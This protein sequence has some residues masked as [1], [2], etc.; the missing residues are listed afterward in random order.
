MNV[1]EDNKEEMEEK[2]S[3]EEMEGENRE[4][5]PRQE[6]ASKE[7]SGEEPKAEE[8]PNEE[9]SGEEEAPVEEA[10]SDEGDGES[11]EEGAGM[12]GGEPKERGKKKMADL[13]KPVKAGD[14]IEVTIESVGAKGDGIAKKDGFV[15]FVPGV[16]KGDTVK[17]KIVE[18][19]TSFA[20]GEKV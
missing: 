18:L 10:A 9:E 8:A 6:E 12:E 4:E 2:E 11:G 14:E 16:Q 1:T 7:E 3:A 15:I 5:E 17:I 20:I 13:P 19:K